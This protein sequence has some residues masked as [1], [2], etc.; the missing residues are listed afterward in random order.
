MTTLEIYGLAGAVVVTILVAVIIQL[1]DRR[2]TDDDPANT[3]P[4][5]GS[6]QPATARGSRAKGR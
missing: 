6:S 4:N 2:I 3:S 1:L 5:T